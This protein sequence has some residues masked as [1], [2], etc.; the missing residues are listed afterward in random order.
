MNPILLD[1]R[2]WLVPLAVWTAVV[3]ASLGWNVAVIEGEIEAL[4]AVQAREVFRMMESVRLWN[5]RHGGVYV[6]QDADT[7]ANPYLDGREREVETVDGRRLTLVNP[8][9]MTRQMAAPIEELTGLRV[10]ITSL[11]PNNPGNAADPWERAALLAFE[12]GEKERAEVVGEESG[13]VL[14]YMAPLVTHQVCLE[15]HAKQGYRVGDVR[16]G[17]SVSL[18]V[19]PIAATHHD[20]QRNAQLVHLVGWALVAA[21][22]FFAL[23]ASRRQVLA[24]DRARREQEALVEQR[25]AELRREVAERRQAETRLRL[26]VDASG[27]GIFGLGPDGECTFINPV[28]LQLLG[29]DRAETLLGAPILE[30]VV[31]IA[32]QLRVLHEAFRLGQR[33]HSD[34]MVFRRPDGSRF[35]VEVRLDP[36]EGDARGGAV[37]NFADVTLRKAAE[38]SVWHQANHDALTGLANRKLLREHLEQTV[39]QARR[40]GEIVALLFIDL[41]G[42]KAVNDGHG[43]AAGD[44][45]LRETSRRLERGIRES[46]LAARLAGDEFVVILRHLAG[47]P[48]AGAVAAK[49]IATLGEPYRFGTQDLVVA[50]SIGIALYPQDADSAEELLRHADAA[51]YKAKEAGKRTWRYFAG[52]RFAASWGAAT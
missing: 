2:Y 47:E 22:A 19:A 35:D 50:A 16:G 23:S 46:D 31:P 40:G 25:T 13:P 52:G 44:C 30:C 17:I 29:V 41:D 42:F 3:L 18:P 20:Q 49:L 10:H 26:L 34:E 32:E 45:V 33:V 24:L 51:M 37:V 12:Y 11:K 4:S 21:L 39:A 1:R 14:R 8:A 7:P 5:A 28:A 48:Y 15:C 43:H 6:A 36:I 9:Y 27:N 38:A